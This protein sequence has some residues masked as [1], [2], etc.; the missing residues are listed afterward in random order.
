MNM[1]EASYNA[2]GPS[3]DRDARFA[4]TLTLSFGHRD[5][6]TGD[7]VRVSVAIPAK[8]VP[9]LMRDVAQQGGLLL[10]E[11]ANAWRAGDCARCG[12]VRLVKDEHN[13]SV[14]CP[15]CS[16]TGTRDG[17]ADFPVVRSE[18]TR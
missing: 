4:G 13:R 15:A 3:V 14:H 8:Y 17:L 1:T 16:P 11:I 5:D 12:N 9:D 6:A 18:V 2:T 7:Y 10:A